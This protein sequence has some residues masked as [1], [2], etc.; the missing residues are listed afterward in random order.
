[1]P[2]ELTPEE[3]GCECS[4]CE[5]GNAPPE[6]VYLQWH[7]DW[8]PGGYDDAALEGVT[9]CVDRINDDDIEYVPTAAVEAERAKCAKTADRLA[10]ILAGEKRVV[11]EMVADAIREGSDE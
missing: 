1:M 7:S 2:T 4:N 8:L 5:N 6:I 10:A 11:V 9:W 3:R